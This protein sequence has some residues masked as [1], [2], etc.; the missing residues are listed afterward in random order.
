MS[1]E[2]KA[3]EGWS[4]LTKIKINPGLKS[5]LAIPSRRSLPSWPKKKISCLS[6]WQ[7]SS[8]QSTIQMPCFK[9]IT[10]VKLVMMLI[11]LHEQRWLGGEWSKPKWGEMQAALRQRLDRQ[12]P[13]RGLRWA[14]GMCPEAFSLWR[15][16]WTCPWGA[17]S[18]CNGCAFKEVEG[19]LLYLLVTLLNT[20]HFCR[21][22][23]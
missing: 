12:S 20:P 15:C 19:N 5:V 8:A 21:F 11:C 2:R 4:D 18:C 9:E 7:R 13:A 16:G 23:L 3:L 6:C 1:L 22:L 10:S 17:F 14:A